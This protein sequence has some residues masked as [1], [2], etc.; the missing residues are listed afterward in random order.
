[1]LTLSA[2]APVLDNGFTN[3]DDDVYV[4]ANR[5]IQQGLGAATVRWAFTTVRAANWHPVTWVSHAIDWTSFGPA[6]RGHHAT[7][8]ALHVGNVVLLFLVLVAMTGAPWRCALAAALFAVHPL[9]VE[10]VAWVAE[11]K[12]VLSTTFWLLA[13]AAYVRYARTPSASRMALVTLLMAIGLL[14]KPMLV[15]LP[16][17]LLLLDAWPLAREDASWRGRIVEK[18]P[19]MGLAAASAAVTVWAQR[20]GGAIASV[21]R[22]P[23]EIRIANAIRS[24]AAYL[25]KT[26]WPSGLAAFYP[27]PGARSLS[28]ATVLAALALIAVTA[29]AWRGYR[30]RPYLLVGWLWFL[31]TLVPVIGLVQVGKQGMADRYTYVP[32]IGPFVAAAWLAAEAGRRVVVP[33]AA[34]VVTLVVLT[35]AQVVIWH[36]SITLFTRAIAVTGGSAPARVN[37]GAALE[38]AGDP[39]A[40][41]RAYEEAVR[42]DPD[43]RAAQNRIAGILAR[44]GRLEDAAARYRRVLAR[45]PDDPETESN[46]GIVLAKSGAL[47]EAIER[48]RAALALQPAEP[49][50]IHTNLGNVLLLAGRVEEAIAE[51]RESL[52]LDPGD[53]ET[54]ANLRVATER[55]KR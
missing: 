24:Y 48:F 20:A 28:S 31:V 32:L 27:H 11:R 9:H 33:A 49:A 42:L 51:Y 2:F 19:L 10:S 43:N 13:T 17:T 12:D 50:S 5:H 4:T 41:M 39:A 26:M 6:P 30:R 34:I 37:L 45:H 22:F 18:L 14:A 16:L 3:Y 23:V 40:A 21:E 25:G 8:L 46:L 38:D 15:T 35:R 7:S 29:C 44:E 47:D 53:R 54:E 52:R 55:L 36:D 1:M